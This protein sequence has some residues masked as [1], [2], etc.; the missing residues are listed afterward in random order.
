M[1][2]LSSLLHEPET[3]IAVV[4]ATDDS[5]KYGYVIYRDLKRKGFPVFAVNKSRKTVDGDPAFAALAKIPKKTTIVNFVVPPKQG[6]PV[7]QQCLDLNLMNIWIQPGAENPQVLAFVQ[8]N[9]FN[10]VANSCI[11]VESRFRA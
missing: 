1:K 4:G 6:L 10:Y 3:S 11:M 5:A 9:N 2:D 7:L 8:E